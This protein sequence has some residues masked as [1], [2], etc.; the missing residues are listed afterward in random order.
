MHLSPEAQQYHCNHRGKFR[1]QPAKDWR[2]NIS[3]G[4]LALEGCR[5]QPHTFVGL[6]N[7]R[8][9]LDVAGI[10][11]RRHHKNFYSILHPDCCLTLH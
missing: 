8:L 11:E 10:L 7:L 3:L 9:D 1:S 4:P 5:D 6:L 2:T